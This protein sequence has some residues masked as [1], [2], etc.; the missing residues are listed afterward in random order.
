MATINNTYARQKLPVPCIHTLIKRQKFIKLFPFY[1]SCTIQLNFN[2]YC[3]MCECPEKKSKPLKWRFVVWSRKLTIL[4]VQNQSSAFELVT[5]NTVILIRCCFWPQIT[6]LHL[7]GL[8]F[9]PGN[10][11]IWFYIYQVEQRVNIQ[12]VKHLPKPIV[13]NIIHVPI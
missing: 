8:F 2:M 5:K 4:T 3:Y 1:L 9:S 6:N 11:Q 10:I 13:I 7:K 12:Y